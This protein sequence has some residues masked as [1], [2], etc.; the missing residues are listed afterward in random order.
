MQKNV[1]IFKRTFF[2]IE[3]TLFFKTNFFGV[4]ILRV[5]I[6]CSLLQHLLSWIFVE[7]FGDGLWFV[8]GQTVVRSSLLSA[9][10]DGGYIEH[11]ATMF[12]FWS[13]LLS[14]YLVYKYKLELLVVEL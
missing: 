9:T 14:T 13:F 3:R 11:L 10:T 7:I 5:L 4:S 8:G 1:N 6:F 12:L 2:L